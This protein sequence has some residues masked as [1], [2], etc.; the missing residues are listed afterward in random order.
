[1]SSEEMPSTFPWWFNTARVFLPAAAADDVAAIDVTGVNACAELALGLTGL[2]N[3][4]S[5]Q[6][7][8]ASERIDAQ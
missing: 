2:L 7:K 6:P 4:L 1:M 3:G 8:V 5:L